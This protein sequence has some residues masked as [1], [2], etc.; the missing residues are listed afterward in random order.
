[1]TIKMERMLPTK[2]MDEAAYEEIIRLVKEA[3]AWEQ[4][5]QMN[6]KRLNKEFW[7]GG[8]PEGLRKELKGYVVEEEVTGVRLKKLNGEE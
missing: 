8:L 6:G 5:S 1:V 3:G 4:V 7:M 2:S